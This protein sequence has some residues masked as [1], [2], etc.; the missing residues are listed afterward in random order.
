MKRNETLWIVAHHHDYG[1]DTFL[2]RFKSEAK[3]MYTDI[4]NNM[5][6]DGR[7][8]ESETV[9]M[10]E[11]NLNRETEIMMTLENF[12]DYFTSNDEKSQ[13]ERERMKECAVDF[14]EQDDY[15]N[16][17]IFGKEDNT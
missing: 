13:R 14:L 3:K 6:S 9:V 16:D 17:R 5:E 7:G 10:D 11:C 12:I 8:D 1:L 2:Y 15:L 4:K